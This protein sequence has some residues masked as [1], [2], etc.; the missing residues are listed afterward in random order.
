MKPLNAIQEIFNLKTG[1]ITLEQDPFR[2]DTHESVAKAIIKF[3]R[4]RALFERQESLV[5]RIDTILTPFIKNSQGT[6]SFKRATKEIIN[7]V[8]YQER[9]GLGT[10]VLIIE[11]AP[12]TIPERFSFYRWQAHDT[13]GFHEDLKKEATTR[14][15]ARK[16][17]SSE[18]TRTFQRLEREKQLELLHA[19]TPISPILPSSLF[20]PF[21]L[22]TYTTLAPILQP[23]PPIAFNFNTLIHHKLHPLVDLKKQFFNSLSA[24][25][26]RKRGYKM[27]VDVHQAIMKNDSEALDSLRMKLLS[28]YEDVRQPYYG[29]CSKTSEFVTGLTPFGKDNVMLDY[30]E[31]SELEWDH[32]VDMDD[33]HDLMLSSPV[34]FD[35]SSSSSEDESS[36]LDKN[37]KR[38]DRWIVP[39][40]YL[41]DNENR[42]RFVKCRPA[43][44]PD[45]SGIMN[46][47]ILG[48][49][50][51]S[52]HEHENHPLSDYKLHRIEE[53]PIEGCTAFNK[54]YMNRNEDEDF[55]D[56]TSS[57]PLATVY[58]MDKEKKK[59]SKRLSEEDHNELI[60]TIMENRSKTLMSIM[61]S[62][63]LKKILGEYTS[64]QLQ[65]IIHDVAVQEVRGGSKEYMWYIKS[66]I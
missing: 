56:M 1:K 60:L 36:V 34:A 2:P 4:W 61:N 21:K 42:K 39:D 46:T 17:F 13:T 33:V 9:Y 20:E 35:T 55:Q 38:E 63:R 28:F 48:P 10:V 43:Q 31:D 26:K 59:K 11:D 52:T 22:N 15:D 45:S 66:Q 16:Q 64:D 41:T 14:H 57:Q 29:T 24:Q 44:V 50:F 7:L 18:V 54:V 5:T 32:D 3:R 49:S 27:D 47:V 6:E 37:E 40:G 51:E 30:D 25:A 19:T 23:Q 62:I 53:H 12:S 8:A 65:A 58:D